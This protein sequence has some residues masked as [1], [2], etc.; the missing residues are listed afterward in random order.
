MVGEQPG[1]AALTGQAFE[2]YQL[3]GWSTAIHPDDTQATIAAWNAAVAARTPFVFEHR[4]RRHDGIWRTFAVRAMPIFDAAGNISEWVGVHHDITDDRAAKE[5]IARNAETFARLIASNPFGIY[6]VNADFHLIQISLGAQAVFSGITPLIGRRFDEIINLVWQDP[7]ATEV[8]ARFHHTL[9]TGVPYVSFS[10]VERRANVDAVEAY[11]WRIERISLPDGRFGVVCYF[12]DLSERNA[13]EAKLMQALADKDLLAREIDH[14]V[15]NSLTIVASL[16]SMQ[17]GASASEETRSALAEAADR[18]IAVARV[19]ER[20]HKSH[21]VGLV[22]FG[23]Y[24][25]QMFADLG[26]SM[27]GRG[28][29]LNCSAVS[30]NLPA[31]YAMSLSLITNELVTN[32]FKHGSEA[33]A[34]I[35]G[36]TLER[37]AEALVLTVEDNGSGMPISQN[38]TSASLGFKLITALARQLEASVTIPEA[39]QPARFAIEIPI[40]VLRNLE[41]IESTA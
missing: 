7:F 24:L 30:V 16:L 23:E 34:T 39:G 40:S 6:V 12:Y 14:R 28:L 22:A 8:I 19:H 20:L 17:R 26:K 13:Y 25:E 31:E 38:E 9:D 33:G 41:Q 2:D 15:K 32:A 18:V 10:T 37:H 5:L 4:V 11:D 29:T 3:Y 1:W 21:H 35:I 27:R 36:V